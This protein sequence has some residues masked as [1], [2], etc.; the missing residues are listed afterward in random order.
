MGHIHFRMTPLP[1]AEAKGAGLPAA[2]GAVSAVEEAWQLVSPPTFNKD[3]SL[4]NIP[5][6]DEDAL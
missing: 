5:A 4:V 6:E 3:N 1:H 2:R